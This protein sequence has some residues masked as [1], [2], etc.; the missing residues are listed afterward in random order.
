MK[1]SKPNGPK[2]PTIHFDFSKKPALKVVKEGSKRKAQRNRIISNLWHRAGIPV[3]RVISR[4]DEWTTSEFIEG[5]TLAT[6]TGTAQLPDSRVQE[7]AGLL[8]RMHSVKPR[9]GLGNP[10]RWKL[11][12]H[13]N[14]ELVRLWRQKGLTSGQALRIAAFLGIRFPKKPVQALAHM[15]LSSN[16]LVVRSNNSL[17]VIDMGGVKQDF[18][19]RELARTMLVLRMPARQR[20]EFLDAY[21]SAGGQTDSF[22]KHRKFW[23]ALELVHQL[24]TINR[25]LKIVVL[26]EEKKSLEKTF[27]EFKKELLDTVS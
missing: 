11:F 16:N 3:Q 14:H 6:Q 9:I 7:I 15:D 17:A 24:E 18:R 27:S 26:T 23:T 10:K 12:E 5:Q 20:N 1:K 8:A 21:K 13:A 19:D 22:F 2:P 25:R 4:K